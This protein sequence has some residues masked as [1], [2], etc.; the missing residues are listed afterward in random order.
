MIHIKKSGK[1][2]KREQKCKKIYLFEENKTTHT[3]KAKESRVKSEGR[4]F[5]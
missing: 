3:D 2:G 1:G 5:T 4:Q